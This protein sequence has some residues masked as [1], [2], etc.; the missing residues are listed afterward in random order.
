LTAKKK[1]FIGRKKN[2]NNKKKTKKNKK[3]KTTHAATCLVS[4]VQISNGL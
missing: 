4:C 1:E 3:T 2:Q